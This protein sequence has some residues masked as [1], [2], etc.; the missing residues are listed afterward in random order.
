MLDQNTVKEA[1]TDLNKALKVLRMLKKG[2]QEFFD[3]LETQDQEIFISMLENVR[4]SSHHIEDELT[5]S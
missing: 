3:N 1:I 5:G 4:E 2:G